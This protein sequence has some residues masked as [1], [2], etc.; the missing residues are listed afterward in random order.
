[1]LGFVYGMLAC[2]SQ[3][4]RDKVK[5]LQMVAEFRVQNNKGDCGGG[6]QIRDISVIKSYIYNAIEKFKFQHE[7]V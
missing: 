4:S 1:M 3:T 5:I 2:I 7:I 6:K